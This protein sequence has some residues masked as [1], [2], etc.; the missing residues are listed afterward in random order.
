MTVG[1]VTGSREARLLYERL[2]GAVI[3]DGDAVP[4]RLSVERVIDASHP[5]ERETP[6]KIAALCTTQCI[7]Y[8]RLRRKAWEPSAEDHWFGADNANA[9]FCDLKPS[10]KRVFLC[11][12]S[13]DRVPFLTD[14]ERWYLIRTREWG[15]VSRPLQYAF[16][17]KDGPFTVEQEIDLM[18]DHR[19]DV[20]VTRNAGGK[21]AVPK[22][23]AARVMGLP[24]VMLA[25][26]RSPG[27][28]V[29]TVREALSWLGCSVRH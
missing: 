1:I 9:A 21:G 10:W 2:H 28:E 12:G 5:C 25:R 26:P 16:T 3:I 15:H 27:P 18:T 13:A 8:L 17:G 23:S 14:R 6:G 11:L 24:V 19:I 4:D 29:A 7:P 22:V 20:L